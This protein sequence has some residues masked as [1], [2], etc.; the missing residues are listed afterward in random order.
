MIFSNTTAVVRTPSKLTTLLTTHAVTALQIASHLT[1]ITGDIRTP[2]DV[3]ST[4]F[5]DDSNAP[6]NIIISGLGSYPEFTLSKGFV[7]KDPD[8]CHDGMR[9]VLD[10]LAARNPPSSL[11][12]PKPFLV[13]LGTTGVSKVGRDVPFLLVPIY[14]GLLKSAHRD[15]KLMEEVIEKS[16]ANKQD[17]PMGGYTIVHASLLTDG[18]SLGMRRVRSD[19]VGEAWSK[20]AIGYTIS[21]VDVGLWVFE[22]LVKGYEGVKGKGRIARITY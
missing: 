17:C 11:T 10:V 6:V 19:I 3:A 12:S 13:A 20:H 5:A 15:K 22:T 4:I 18:K 2:S 21:R 8:L 16:Y 9:I 1:M 14:Q 7:N